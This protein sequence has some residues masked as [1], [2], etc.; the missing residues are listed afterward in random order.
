M[1]I[2]YYEIKVIHSTNQETKNYIDICHKEPEIREAYPEES[3]AHFENVANINVDSASVLSQEKK[4][5]SIKNC[6]ANPYSK[7]EANKS[8]EQN[9]SKTIEQNVSERIYL[10]A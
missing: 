2:F 1:E 10:K 6:Q 7:N 9:A 4:N 5:G 3:I 8:I